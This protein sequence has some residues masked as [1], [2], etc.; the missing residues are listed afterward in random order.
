[1]ENKRVVKWFWLWEYDQKQL[2]LNKMADEGWLLEKAGVFAYYFVPCR[3]GKYALRAEMRPY[4]EEYVQSA[5]N[6][7]CTYIGK[8]G[9]WLYFYREKGHGYFNQSSDIKFRL[10]YL[11]RAARNTA[12]IGLLIPLLAVMGDFKSLWWMLILPA[13]VL[14]ALLGKL[15]GKIDKLEKEMRQYDVYL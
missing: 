3:V 6:G 13:A 15:H 5:V 11:Q 2:W 12:Y 14:L 10:Y 7:G 9:K 8:W 4:N 1:M